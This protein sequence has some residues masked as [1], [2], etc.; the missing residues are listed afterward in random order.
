MPPTI[1]RVTSDQSQGASREREGAWVTPRSLCDPPPDPN[2]PRARPA[3]GSAPI[4][5]ARRFTGLIA[6]LIRA[7]GDAARAHGDA[8]LASAA[9]DGGYGWSRPS[10]AR[11]GSTPAAGG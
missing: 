10:P 4:A 9:P 8:V 7:N 11:R 3:A 5:P 1:A 6:R 2:R